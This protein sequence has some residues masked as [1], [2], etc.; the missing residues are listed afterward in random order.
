MMTYL[1]LILLIVSAK[2]WAP[3]SARSS[4]KIGCGSSILVLDKYT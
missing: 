2:W 4:V 1:C 3:L